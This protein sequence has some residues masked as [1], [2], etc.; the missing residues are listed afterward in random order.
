MFLF[1]IKRVLYLILLT[2]LLSNCS[3]DDDKVIIEDKEEEQKEVDDEIFTLSVGSYS[4]LWNS[5]ASNGSVYTNLDI[6]AKIT[7]IEDGQITGL[8]YISS[9]FTSCCGSSGGNDGPLSFA[10]L[11]NEV[12]DF[13]WDDIIPDCNGTFTGAGTIVDHDSFSIQINKGEDCE[14]THSNTSIRL[15]K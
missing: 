3:N 4:G 7:Q 15:S 12:S 2:F 9:D 11:D 5:S 6:T 13:K 14:G 10:I 1:K 8:L